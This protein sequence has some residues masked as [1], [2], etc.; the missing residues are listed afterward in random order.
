MATATPLVS[1][2]RSICARRAS[3]A[4]RLAWRS[5]M[6]RSLTAC[7]T[8]ISAARAATSDSSVLRRSPNS[9]PRCF[10]SCRM[11]SIAAREAVNNDTSLPTTPNYRLARP[12]PHPRRTRFPGGA[13][14]GDGDT[15]G[16]AHVDGAVV[17]GVRHPDLRGEGS[18]QRLLGA[19]AVDE[20][21]AA[22]LHLLQDGLDRRA[23]GG[24]T[25]P[26]AA[27]DADVGAAAAEHPIEAV[28]VLLRRE[29]GQQ[30]LRSGVFIGKG[31]G[32]HRQVDEN[33]VAA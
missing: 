3:M 28:E 22:L 13:G 6:E 4:T 17:D 31:R 19:A 11:G 1:A 18:D 12:H 16:L 32:L 10:L 2:M 8:P 20:Q 9:R 33:L 5:S 7:G 21:Q 14:R 24:E 29:A 26:H 23:R 27:G 25:R 15:A 30:R